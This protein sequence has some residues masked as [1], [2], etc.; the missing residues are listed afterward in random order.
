VA[1]RVCSKCG[2]TEFYSEG[3]C[4]PC[5]KAQASKWH[6]E[7]PERRKQIAEKAARKWAERNPGLR[8]AI[9]MVHYAFNKEVHRAR[10]DAW[11]KRNPSVVAQKAARRRAVKRKA[12]PAWA[13]EFFISEA[14]HIAELRS[15]VTGIKWHVDHIVPLRSKTV[16]GLHVEHN[17]QVIPESVNLAKSNRYWPDQP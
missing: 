11:F 15:K 9:S 7:H 12:T 1:N 13:N 3:H 16:C 8:A 5:K 2:S 4:K 10:S 17:L 14:Y 6:V